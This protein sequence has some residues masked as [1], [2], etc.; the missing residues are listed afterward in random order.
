MRLD[1]Y[2]KVARIIKRRTLSKEMLDLGRVYIDGRVAKPSTEVKIN[3]IL[4]IKMRDRSITIK[5]LN[6]KESVKAEEANS[7]YE[8]IGEEIYG[9]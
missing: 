4:T 5:V 8:V 6:I 2:L 3:S 1:K 7:L 9:K